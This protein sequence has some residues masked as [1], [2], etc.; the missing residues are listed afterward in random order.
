LLNDGEHYGI[1]IF[2]G[3]DLKVMGHEIN[4]EHWMRDSNDRLVPAIAFCRCGSSEFK[5][6]KATM[7]NIFEAEVCINCNRVY[8]WYLPGQSSS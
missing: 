5:T 2:L 1:E 3:E 8:E 4:L 7:G 6:L